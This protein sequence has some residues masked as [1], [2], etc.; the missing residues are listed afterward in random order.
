MDFFCYPDKS[1]PN[2]LMA[3]KKRCHALGCFGYANLIV[4]INIT[5]KF[6]SHSYDCR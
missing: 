4:R 5:L 6:Q 3:P 2:I 1:L